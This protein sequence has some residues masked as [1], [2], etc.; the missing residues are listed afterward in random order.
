LTL[1]GR[2]YITVGR[3]CK[4]EWIRTPLCNG[5]T[6]PAFLTHRNALLKLL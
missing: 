2:N 3:E 6:P 5:I 1:I 4:E